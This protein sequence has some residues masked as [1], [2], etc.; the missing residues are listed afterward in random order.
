MT[1]E[2]TTPL[3]RLLGPD[4]RMEDCTGQAT[5]GRLVGVEE[6]CRRLM[7]KCVLQVTGY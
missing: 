3:V 2:Q 7:A 1:R 5:M 6:T 4:E